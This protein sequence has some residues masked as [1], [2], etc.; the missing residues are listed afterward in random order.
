[1]FLYTQVDTIWC[2]V[3]PSTLSGVAQTWF[4]SLKLGIMSGFSQLSFTFSTHF[5]S[6]RCCERT[7]GELLSIK[8]GETQSLRDFTGRLNVEAVSIPRLRQDVAV[9][10]LMIGLK[11]GSAF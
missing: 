4:K 2:K 7:T 10:V 5:V 11:E 6:N 8:Q 9:L 3:F 1:M